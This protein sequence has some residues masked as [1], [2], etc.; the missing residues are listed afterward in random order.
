MNTET[1]FP[2][3]DFSGLSLNP[4]NIVLR[5]TKNTAHPSRPVEVLADLEDGFGLLILATRIEAMGDCQEALLGI[6]QSV[7]VLWAH[8]QYQTQP[9]SA[10]TLARRVMKDTTKVLLTDVREKLGILE[11]IQLQLLVD[12]S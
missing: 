1:S 10:K 9:M 11:H 6:P 7:L 5:S 4:L 3:Q 12:H 2:V 8:L